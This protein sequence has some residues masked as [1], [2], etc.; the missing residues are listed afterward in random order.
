MCGKEIERGKNRGRRWG[1]S[2]TEKIERALLVMVRSDA[3][4]PISV[5]GGYWVSDIMDMTLKINGHHC[6][7]TV[8][9]I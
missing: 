6:K 2:H 5:R 1:S 9:K 4:R 3:H 7:Y 8:Y